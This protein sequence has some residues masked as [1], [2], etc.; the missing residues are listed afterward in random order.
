[1]AV[2]GC[3]PT[4]LWPFL[5]A[6]RRDGPADARKNKVAVLSFWRFLR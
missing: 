1:L 6:G 2:V 4:T 3:Y 5:R